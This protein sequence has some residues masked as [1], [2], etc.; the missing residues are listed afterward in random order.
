METEMDTGMET[1]MDEARRLRSLCGEYELE[2]REILSK[3]TDWGLACI[4]NGIGPESF[5]A[6]LRA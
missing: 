6:W 4:F 2:G 1:E 3:Y 5:P